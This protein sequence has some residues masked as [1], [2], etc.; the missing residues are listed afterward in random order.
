MKY[1]RERPDNFVLKHD[2]AL[3]RGLVFAGLGGGGI[4]SSRYIDS[5][6]YGNNGTLTSMVPSEDWVW[7]RGRWVLDFDGSNDRVAVARP[8]IN[9]PMTLSC[10][11]RQEDAATNV[12][13]AIVVRTADD[14]FRSIY[15]AG[16]RL[17]IRERDAS[18]TQTTAFSSTVTVGGWTHIC[19]VIPSITARYGYVDGVLRISNTTYTADVADSTGLRIGINAGSAGDAFLGRIADPLIYNRVLSLPEIQ[20]LAD[21][22]NTLLSGLIQPPR[23]KYY[24]IQPTQYSKR[25]FSFNTSIGSF[26]IQT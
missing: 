25:F 26:S 7:E 12:R 14:R 6:G 23:R 19:G 3:A 8:A 15:V 1:L 2:H 9:V 18:G 13:Y 20:Q 4:G 22:S 10:W 11:V 16:N 21:P 17:Y 5:S 24:G